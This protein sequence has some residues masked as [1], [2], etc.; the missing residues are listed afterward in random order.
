[1]RM[2]YIIESSYEGFWSNEIGWVED[3]ESATH[4]TGEE[5]EIFDLPY[6]LGKVGWKEVK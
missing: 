5:R 2:Y 6:G 3:R 4:F 1:M